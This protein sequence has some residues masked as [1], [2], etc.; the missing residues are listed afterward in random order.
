VLEK[1]VPESKDQQCPQKMFKEFDDAIDG[2]I[3]VTIEHW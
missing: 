2:D 3:I 1:K